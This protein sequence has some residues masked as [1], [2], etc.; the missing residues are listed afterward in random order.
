MKKFIAIEGSTIWDVCLNTY[1]TLDLI[2]KLMTDNNFPGVNEYPK[3]GQVFLYDESLV[4]GVGNT[5]QDIKYAT[6]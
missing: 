5:K 1:G 3:A 6:S 2:V 4:V